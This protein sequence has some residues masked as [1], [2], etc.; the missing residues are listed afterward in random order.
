MIP[1]SLR[2]RKKYV[3]T[4]YRAFE[5]E[6]RPKYGFK[7]K[8][9][10][11]EERKKNERNEEVLFRLPDRNHFNQMFNR[12]LMKDEMKDEEL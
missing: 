1:T 11:K 10:K 4:K 7:R 3:Y 2:F 5:G 12:A 6:K 9:R 8:N